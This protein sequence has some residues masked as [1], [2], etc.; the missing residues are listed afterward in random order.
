[1]NDNFGRIF[2]ALRMEHQ[3]GTACRGGREGTPTSVAATIMASYSN[4]GLDPVPER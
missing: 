2:K 4:N 3:G 1:M